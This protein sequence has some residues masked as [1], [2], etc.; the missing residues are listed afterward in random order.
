LRAIP[1]SLCV[2][3]KGHKMLCGLPACPL[4]ERFRSVLNTTVRLAR[5]KGEVN[6][7]TPPSAIV[8]E[9]NYPR[10]AILYNVPPYVFGSE[11]RNYEDPRGWWGKMSL[12]D[13]IRL[14]SSLVSLTTL[15][16]VKDPWRLY[17]R[18]ISLSVVSQTPVSTEARIEGDLIPSLKFDGVILP[19]G[20]TARA[21]SIR[22]AENPKIGKVLES[23]IN[24]DVKA[25]L[26]VE[27][28]YE[29]GEDYYKIIQALSLGLL[30]S[31]R[32]RRMVPT[33]W[34]ITAVDQMVSS[35]LLKEVRSYQVVNG[36]SVL[37][38]RYLGNYFHVILYPSKF[39]A[40][41]IEIWHPMTA[42]TN[43]T[44]VVELEEDFWGE[45]EYMDGGYIAAKQGILEL[46]RGMKRQ[47]GVVIIRE[48]TNEYFASVGNWHIRE[49]VRRA[50]KLTEAEDLGRALDVVQQRLKALVDLKKLKSLRA[51]LTQQTIDKF[52][53]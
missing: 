43:E 24:D 33:R 25:S 11:A 12:L 32:R 36:V 6:G 52:L 17:E 49:T 4:M 14:R 46:L 37:Y 47:A 38:S 22:V 31:K 16:N 18:E 34:A 28:L 35:L 21:N 19:R 30:G 9:R 2:K 13:I 26:A 45:M 27:R 10:V 1:A 29:A 15:E 40:T 44:A 7:A 53:K 20:P 5:S 41:W 51:L 3:C 48:I 50:G 39:R 8:G 42:W 23:L